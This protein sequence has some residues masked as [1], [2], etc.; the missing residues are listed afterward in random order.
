M[1]SLNAAD[2]RWVLYFRNVGTGLIFTDEN[3]E[4]ACLL[5]RHPQTKGSAAFRPCRPFGEMPVGRITETR[6]P[7]SATRGSRARS[8]LGVMQVL[9]QVQWPVSRASGL[10]GSLDTGLC[11]AVPPRP[12]VPPPG[13]IPHHCLAELRLRP[14][15]S[16]LPAGPSAWGPHLEKGTS[17][18]SPCGRCPA[19]DSSHSPARVSS[20]LPCAPEAGP[21]SPS[22]T[23]ARKWKMDNKGH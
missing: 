4:P 16:W 14:H 12:G 13:W 8:C 5:R 11:S 3:S 9:D 19:P 7:L 6:T 15:G 18:I 22:N 21:H 17:K 10:P 23:Q 1:G 2:R 20:P